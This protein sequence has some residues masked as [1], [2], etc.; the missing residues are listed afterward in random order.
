MMPADCFPVL[1]C[2]RA[3]REMAAS[4]A[5]W[6]GLCAGVLEKTLAAFQAPRED[7]L[8]WLNPAIGPTAFEVGARLKTPLPITTLQPPASSSRRAKI[9]GRSL[10]A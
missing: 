10:L 6:R 1:F 4:H 5:D 2:D 7:I 8:A 9:S 3:E